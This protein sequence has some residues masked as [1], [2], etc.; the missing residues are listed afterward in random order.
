MAWSPDG[1]TLASGADDRTIRLWNADTGERQSAVRGQDGPVYS[2]AWSPDGRTLASGSVHGTI[3][4]L[5]TETGQRTTLEGHTDSI[6]SVAFSGDGLLL[7]SKADSVRLW[8]C[9]TWEVIA[10][11]DEP[12]PG[13][14]S[15]TAF[16]PS[17]P[18]LATLG[19]RDTVIRIWNL[20][21]NTLLDAAPVTPSL[22]YTNAKVVLVGDSGVGKSGLGLVLSGQE[23]VPTELTHG[24]HIWTL[25]SEEAELGVGR[26]ELRETLLWD[27]AGQPGYR[28][29]HQ[30]H[31]GEV[32]VALIVFDARS[33]LDPFAGVRHWDRAL[34]QARRAR[35]E[36]ALPLKKFLV[37]ARADRG[38]IGVGTVRL[39][40]LLEELSFDGYFET[41]AKEGWR[42][43]ELNDAVRESIDWEQT[44]KVRSN[45]L[46][47]SIKSFL[48]R[49]KASGRL[50][51]TVEDLYRAYLASAEAVA[52]TRDLADQFQTCIGRVELTGLIRRLSFGGLVLLQP[53]MLD[54]YASA[55]VNAA[56]DEPD[57]MGC[58]VEDVARAGNFRIP[59]D[60]RIKDKE[61]EKLLLIAMV[62]DLLR[63]EITLREVTPDGPHLVFPTQFTLRHPRLPSPQ[64]KALVFRFEGPVQ[65]V[66]ATLAVRLAH[67]GVFQKKA[68][69][70]DAATY[71][72]SVGGTCGMILHEMAEG[73]GEITLFFDDASIEETRFQFEEFI[74]AHLERRALRDT[75]K[76]RRIFVCPNLGCAVEFTEA[77]VAQWGRQG[78]QEVPCPFCSNGTVSLLDRQ[79]RLESAIKRRLETSGKAVSPH[80]RENEVRQVSANVSRLAEMGRNADSQRDQEVA[81]SILQGKTL[82]GDF[83]VFLCHNSADK[84]AVTEIG[85]QLKQQGILPWLD[86]E[87]LRPGMP[88]QN[89]LEKQIESIKAAAVFVGKKGLGPWQD[90]EQAAFLRQFVR[91]NCP[92]IPVILADSPK[93][94]PRLPPF[95]EGMTWVDFRKPA[96]DPIQQLIWGITG[97]RGAS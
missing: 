61:Q 53:E 58:I 76:R 18:I 67:S 16:H 19:E 92:V 63:H 82:T 3:A 9:S 94:T 81:M 69:W 83:D 68:M 62:E 50:L 20:D 15:S 13:R 49:E 77:Q 6:R 27:L 33:E 65:N 70:Q 97:Q 59:S 11:L 4:L 5:D 41:S 74:E 22:R 72:A 85:D 12:V 42:I 71:T 56:K 60:E 25:A 88:W 8:R 44:L 91:R 80:E 51:S 47:L 30:L 54:A 78:K 7:A 66:Y 84:P 29:V 28:L 1:R 23:F 45:E 96:P 39:K 46:F 31:L 64:G 40:E 34:V 90:M 95:L 26:K 57:G 36:A 93:K 75:I 89:E 14:F 2:L 21:V 24:R 43:A 17:D 52:D 87:Q 35:G 48:V 55:L 10:I 86:V 79:A 37:A 32:T 38:G 73:W